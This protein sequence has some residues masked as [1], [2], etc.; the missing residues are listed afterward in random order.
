MWIQNDKGV[1]YK[2]YTLLG[3]TKRVYYYKDPKRLP[4]QGYKERMR[5][6]RRMNGNKL[7]L[8]KMLAAR[9]AQCE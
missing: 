5:R 4:H 6:M 3:P 2:D 8:G 1:I 7:P 9:G